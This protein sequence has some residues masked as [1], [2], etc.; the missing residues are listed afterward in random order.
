M[1][2]FS[3]ELENVIIPWLLLGTT[4]FGGENIFLLLATFYIIASEAFYKFS[5]Y[6]S[7]KKGFKQ[8]VLVPTS[9]WFLQIILRNKI[10]VPTKTPC[11][12][13]HVN[14][15]FENKKEFLNN[16][17]QDV[18]LCKNMNIGFYVGNTFTSFEHFFQKSFD[19]EHL[20]VW[21]GTFFGHWLQCWRNQYA[22]WKIYCISPNKKLIAKNMLLT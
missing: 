2:F 7:R 16:I 12:V 4:I 1:F 8:F 10:E 3:K 18:E 6:R 22:E 15:L 17:K 19:H 5:A 11:Y 20:A 13:I 9:K 14:N 21:K